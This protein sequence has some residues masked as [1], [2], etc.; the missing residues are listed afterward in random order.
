MSAYAIKG[1][2]QFQTAR[3]GKQQ[4]H[5][6]MGEGRWVLWDSMGFYGYELKDHQFFPNK[7][8]PISILETKNHLFFG[9]PILWGEALYILLYVV[10]PVRH[11]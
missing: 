5:K 3:C 10:F 9:N 4:N 1:T 8:D 11:S 7:M 6:G 2:S